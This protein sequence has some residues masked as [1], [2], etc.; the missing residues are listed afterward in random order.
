M[1]AKKI[2]FIIWR[3]EIKTGG[4]KMDYFLWEIVKKYYV[5]ARLLELDSVTERFPQ[6]LDRLSNI[7]F[8][9]RTIMMILYAFVMPKMRNT[10]IYTHFDLS[11]FLFL[12]LLIMKYCYSSKI[13]IYNHL[14]DYSIGKST[15]NNKGKLFIENSFMRFANMILT[16]SVYS[17]NRLLSFGIPEDKIKIIYPLLLAWPGNYEPEHKK[18]KN[19]TNLLFVGTNFSRKGLKSLLLALE[20]LNRHDIFLNIVGDTKEESNLRFIKENSALIEKLEN[21]KII[22]LLGEVVE[23]HRKEELFNQADAFVMPSLSEGFGIV[24]AEAMSYRLPVIA[25]NTTAIPELVQEGCNGV[26]VPPDDTKALAKAI[27]KLADNRDLRIKMG[28]NGYKKIKEFYKSYSI[29]N[30]LRSVLEGLLI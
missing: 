28:D 13:I 2:I 7:R 15:N 1:N 6:W 30:E 22:K 8:L 25:T 14:I 24:F 10:L 12:Y 5:G 19:K 29:E 21:K 11:R 4:E 9:R 20:V 26:L 17:K 3:S 18:I 27:E 16:N 23:S